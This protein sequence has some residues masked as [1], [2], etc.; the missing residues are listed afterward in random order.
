MNDAPDR[1]A[2]E[3][4]IEAEPQSARSPA[5]LEPPEVSLP[6]LPPPDPDSRIA[7]EVK[8]LV[9]GGDSA[10]ARERFDALVLR[11]QR[12]ASRIAY[13]FLRDA[14]DADEAVQDAFLKVFSH[15][16]SFREDL[17]FEVWFTR[18][19]INGCLDRQKARRRRTRWLTPALDSEQG[20]R[21]WADATSD[22]SLSPEASVLLKERRR[23]IAR[24]V[25]CLPDRQRTIFL[26]CHYEG[27]SSKEASAITG[28]NESTVRVH[29]FRAVRKLRALLGGKL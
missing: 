28:L 27:C 3:G 10:G 15:I 24:A 18:I 14:A 5:P 7:A 4:M 9:Q 25:G 22:R 17:P 1:R 11:Q 6:A 8:A 13:H 16:E 19:L 12:R 23:Q 29:L 26:L 20:E 21:A 2:D